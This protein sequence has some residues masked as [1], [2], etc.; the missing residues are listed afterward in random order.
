[1][2]LIKTTE[3]IAKMRAG[4]RI[5]A[6]VLNLAAGK[7]KPGIKTKDLENFVEQELSKRGAEPAFKNFQGY[8][9][10][11]CVSLNDQ[12]VHGIPGERAIKKGDLISL[13]L[14]VRYQGMYTDAALSRTVVKGSREA[15]S[16]IEITAKSLEAAIAEVKPGNTLG[17][18]GAAIE[19][20]ARRG[21]FN[22][23]RDLV[24]HGVGH[25]V[26]EEPQIPNFGH[27]GQGMKLKPG[28]TLAIEPMLT[29]GRPEIKCLA[30]GWTYVT[31]DGS[32]NAHFEHTVLVTPNGREILTD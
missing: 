17:D 19:N 23:I 24:G 31:A 12:I 18:I 11:L 13:D 1:M 29:S 30:D 6:E 28:M 14:G 9:A 15:Q 4:G 26:H 25:R 2:G 7:I 22:V 32:L 27:P 20:Q 3:E 10:A 16:L 8:P 5:L 21:G